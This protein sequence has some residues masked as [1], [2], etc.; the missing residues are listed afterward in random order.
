MIKKMKKK[1]LGIDPSITS[2]G[3]AVLEYDEDKIKNIITPEK[4]ESLFKGDYKP[5]LLDYDNILTDKD[6]TDRKRFYQIYEQLEKVIKFYKPKVISIEDQYSSLNPKTL[7][8]LSHVR[9]VCMFLAEMYQKEMYLYY[10]TSV[11]KIASGNGRASKED[12]VDAIN[13]YFGLELDF[14]KENDKADAIGIA[15]SY[16][17]DKK[18]GQKI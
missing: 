14:K 10:P 2:T 12:M 4:S 7:K 6:K 9:G 18:K 8:R 1:I 16:L 3:W 11:K 13:E 15:L 17:F 5:E